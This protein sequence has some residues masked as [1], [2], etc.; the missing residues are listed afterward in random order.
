MLTEKKNTPF[1][2]IPKLHDLTHR[3]TKLTEEIEELKSEK[4]VLLNTLNCASDADVS[5]VKKEICTL[6]SSLQKLFEQETKYSAELDDAL[7]QYAELQEQAADFDAAELMNAQLAIRADRESFAVDRVKAAYGE[8]YDSRLM[9]DSK[10]DVVDLLR[11][12]SGTHSVREALR[13]KKHTQAQRKTRSQSE[14]R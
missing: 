11:E 1:Y 14:V 13:Q 4:Q 10:Q 3:I 9:V 7:K 12:K 8:R 6:D 5:A 2:Q